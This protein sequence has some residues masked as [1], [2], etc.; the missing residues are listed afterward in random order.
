MPV[1]RVG[2][3]DVAHYEANWLEDVISRAAA[4][5]GH[6]QWWPAADVARGVIQFLRDR[7]HKNIITLHDLFHKIGQTLQGI[8]FPEIADRIHA[9]PPPLDLFL[10]DFAREAGPGFELLFFRRLSDELASFQEL[11]VTRLHCL[12]IREA[13][14]HLLAAKTWTASCTDFESEILQF[15]RD[16][17]QDNSCAPVAGVLL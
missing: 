6:D 2:Q 3:H 4:D 15:I 1:L 16:S 17:F 14:L 13:V 9:E 8:G 10:L 12:Q 5:A 11:G 7:F